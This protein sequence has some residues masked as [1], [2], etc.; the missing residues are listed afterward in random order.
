ML[1][2]FSIIMFT[3]LFPQFMTLFSSLS[4]EIPSIT[5]LVMTFI[6]LSPY[7]AS[8]FILFFIVLLLYYRCTF[9]KKD[10]IVKANFLTKVPVFG[11]FYKTLLTY[12]F[13]VHLS[14]LLKNGV[15]IL[16]A[17]VIFQQQNAIPF[18]KREA[19]LL[20]ICLERGESLQGILS[21]HRYYHQELVFIVD[22]GQRNGRL[23]EELEYYASWLLQQF[24]QK[25]KFIF[26][27]LQPSLFI[28]I[29]FIVLLLFSSILI[30]IFKM[31]EGI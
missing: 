16:E 15:S 24:R 18:L 2:V 28:F 22:H 3:N 11:W 26:M 17:L 14:C 31:V 13:C 9:K 5:L 30:P 6:R 27:L 19:L 4:I 21:S 29:G 8:L 23:P 25:V 20:K 1:S 12:Y 7:I 10:A